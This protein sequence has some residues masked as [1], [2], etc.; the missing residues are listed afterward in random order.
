MAPKERDLMFVGSGLFGTWSQYHEVAWF[1]EGY[2]PAALDLEALAYYRY[3][4]I[5]AD[6][7]AYGEQIFGVQGSVEDRVE[8]LRQVM[9]QFLPNDVID[10]AHRWYRSIS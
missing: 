8:G 9:G 3:E 7:A 10:F 6:F 5:V 4:R 1:Y 2:G